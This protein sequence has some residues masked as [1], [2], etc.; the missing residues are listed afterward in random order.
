MKTETPKGKKKVAK[1]T[2]RKKKDE[3]TVVIPRPVSPPQQ[4]EAEVT[5]NI[6]VRMSPEPM[7]IEKTPKVEAIQHTETIEPKANVENNETI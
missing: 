4:P 3:T 2:V 5:L 7:E 1:K 6:E